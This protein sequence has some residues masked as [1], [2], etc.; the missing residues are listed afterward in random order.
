[1]I[2]RTIKLVPQFEEDNQTQHLS[3][4]ER[5]AAIFQINVLAWTLAGK[6]MNQP[7]VKKITMVA[8]PWNV[9]E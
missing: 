5:F 7:M 4:N 6:D 2:K 3:V 8:I 9:N 1:M